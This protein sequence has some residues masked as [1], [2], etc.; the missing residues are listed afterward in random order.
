MFD[1]KKIKIDLFAFIRLLTLL[2]N[3]SKHSVHFCF[4]VVKLS[5]VIYKEP[6]ITHRITDDQEQILEELHS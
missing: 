1:L 4:Y 6:R 3:L 5:C 2:I